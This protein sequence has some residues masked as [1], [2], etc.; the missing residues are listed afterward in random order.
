MNFN[1]WTLGAAAALTLAACG[2]STTPAPTETEVET[3]NAQHA[4]ETLESRAVSGV[5]TPDAKHRYITFSYMHQGYSR[6]WV[7]WRAWTGELNWDAET[8]ENSSVSVTIDAEAVDSGVDEFDGHLRGERFFD[9]ANYPA[10][11][12]VSTS[13]AKTGVDTGTITGDL[14]IKGVTK[15]VTLDVKFNKGAY[16]ER[17]NRYKLGFSATTSVI[18]SEFGMDFLVPVVSDQVDIVI[19]T[20]WMMLA[21]ASE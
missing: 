11:T 16:E 3:A 4:T 8:P 15:P 21:P 18:R 12:F 10:V 14:T 19:E 9:T 7:R 13:V 5:Y 1:Y 2:Q 17:G 6:P 20:E